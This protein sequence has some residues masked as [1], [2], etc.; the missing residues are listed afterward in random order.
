M[1]M[2][3][4]T[5]KPP[6]F[7]SRLPGR[8]Q[9]SGNPGPQDRFAYPCDPG[10]GMPMAGRYRPGWMEV[11]KD[12]GWP[13]HVVVVDFET[14]TYGDY[15][16]R[17]KDMSTIQYVK[18]RR[19]EA[20]GVSVL[21]VNVA[22][23]D[24]RNNTKF[25]SRESGVE[26]AFKHLQRLYGENLER[27]TV[28]AMNAKF[29]A[30]IMGYRMGIHPPYFVDLLGLAR[31]W[32]SRAKNDLKVLAKRWGLSAKGD[33]TEFLNVTFK[34][35]WEKP[36]RKGKSKGPVYPVEVPRISPELERKLADYANQDVI[37]E[38]Q[39]FT[40]LLP[41]LS[42]PAT[43]LRLIA[44]TLNLFTQPSFLVDYAKAVELTDLMSKE[45]E[46]VAG[47]TGLT[48]DQLRSNIEFGDTLEQALVAAGDDASQYKKP[49]VP[50]KSNP[51]GL[52]FGLAQDDSALEELLTHADPRVRELVAARVAVK[53]WPTH[54]SRVQRIVEQ[55]KAAGGMLPVPL[56]YCGAHTGRW[57]GGEGL[58]LQNL[59]SR[60]HE[61][62]SAIRELL[63]APPGKT[64]VIVD[65]SQIEARVLAW[66]AGQLD[67]MDQFARGAEIYCGFATQVLGW[68]VRKPK[69]GGIPAIEAKHKWARNTIGK[70]GVLG[71]GYGMGAKRAVGY[72]NGEI[73][74]ATAE[75]IV[76]VYR[77][78]ND[79]IV[80]FWADIERAFISVFKHGRRV[81]LGPITLYKT[82]DADVV[83]RLANGRELKYLDVRLEI[84]RYDR[85]SI[86]IYN[87]S[88]HS[89]DHTWGG[90]LTENVVQAMS[91]DILA[92]A[93]LRMEDRGFPVVHHVHDE[94][95][96][97]V[98]EQGAEEVLAA[99]IEEMGRRPVWAPDCPLAAEGVLSQR[100]GGH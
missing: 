100:Y 40:L 92:E 36:A 68:E 12:A 69:A 8:Y 34:A 75:K 91:R 7:P 45:I 49:C 27:C 94:A 9:V 67:L 50:T 73:D 90:G 32:N 24:Y 64:L 84:G 23:P 86:R 60:G 83:I 1:T 62:V 70:V 13:T 4:P 95:I 18:D 33:T 52:A 82:P 51:E 65:A 38:W 63:I 17:K 37:L 78:T 88:S 29:D 20:L 57:S 6:T 10:Y 97:M 85:E 55:A 42:N 74:L 99:C 61:L 89:W 56:H 31:A 28:V 77:K 59:G 30:A 15:S 19:F 96:A 66:V 48:V 21:E 54:I 3:P 25:W 22:F 43:E 41:R 46:K 76:G 93:V 72:A 71:C 81:T 39:L 79:K 47:P 5:F 53:S 2:P 58:N 14:Y 80:E 35:R 16:L 26:T 44:H 11:L 98:P 87:H